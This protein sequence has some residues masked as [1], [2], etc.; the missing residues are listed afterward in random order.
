MPPEQL[1]GGALAPATDLYAVGL[2]MAEMI[3]GARL[4][5]GSAME[6]AMQQL[7][8]RPLAFP[9][10]VRISPLWPVIERATQKPAGQRFANA[11]GMLAALGHFASTSV[12]AAMP[13]PSQ[14]GY[15]AP[16]SATY[17]AFSSVAPTAPASMP[18][19]P[20]LPAPVKRRSSGLGIGLVLVLL[21]GLG[22]LAVAGVAAAYF[23]DWGSLLGGENA[24]AAAADA[25]V[26]SAGGAVA[27]ADQDGGS[28]T[29][30][31]AAA[32]RGTGTT[33]GPSA[34]GAS[35]TST[36]ASSSTATTTSGKGSSQVGAACVSDKDCTGALQ[37]CGTGGTCQCKDTHS[38][39]KPRQ[40]GSACVANNDPNNCGAC[41]KRCANDQV[42]TTNHG[43]TVEH[44]ICLACSQAGFGSATLLC[45]AH[46]CVSPNSDPRNCGGCNIKCKLGQSCEGGVCK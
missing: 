34:T 4:M 46:V 19:P 45:G 41:G 17:A 39:D 2:I 6:I 8:Q 43:G 37:H 20:S 28:A 44:P 1:A 42:C 21:A 12:A 13:P 9:D 24:R 15:T 32:A 23:V 33:A 10:S 30:A 18:Y 40:C 31:G 3:S 29:P 11:S 27:S 16:A 25:G 22:V 26:P 38:F 14:A 36:T 5:H 7:D 35:T